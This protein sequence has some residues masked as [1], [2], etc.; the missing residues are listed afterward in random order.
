MIAPA[1]AEAPVATLAPSDVAALRADSSPETRAVIAA[2]F[3]ACFERL[4]QVETQD[5][6]HAILGLLVGDM[7]REVRRALAQSIA[8]SGNLPRATALEL[9]RDDIEVATHILEKSPVLDDADLTE[10]VRTNAMQYALAVAGRE[11]ISEGL[12]DALLD[13]GARDVVVRL[14]GNT[15]ARLS[16]AALERV[17]CDWRADTAVQNRLVRRP[18]LPHDM[19]EQMIGFI[20][21]RL[22]WQLIHDRRM[23]A[24]QARII[25]QSVRERAA[26]GMTARE[27]GERRLAEH[28]RHR[29]EADDLHPD[30]LLAFLRDGDVA[31]FEHTLALF[32]ALEPAAV[33]KLAYHPDRRHLAAL[34][35]RAGLPT[36]HY[37]TVRMA[38]ELAETGIHNSGRSRTYAADALAYVRAQY[39]RLRLDPA[40]VDELVEAAA[41]R[42]SAAPAPPP[43]RPE[44]ARPERRA[45]P[46]AL[47]APAAE[48]ALP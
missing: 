4:A 47:P 42:R 3:G 21:D 18:E 44:H 23:P 26:I 16:V 13:T 27:H 31:G 6:A 36:P 5:L 32:A 29:H 11:R 41:P 9:A 30:H 12:C 37:V 7:E 39:D 22:E 28:L 33:R 43:T 25:M 20:G 34:A 1:E 46:A 8:T 35:A 38:L 40:K 24:E 14:A 45:R 48:P 10:I 19:V 2:K 17:F 15:G